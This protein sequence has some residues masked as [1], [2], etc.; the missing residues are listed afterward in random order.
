MDINSGQFSGYGWNGEELGTGGN[1]AN[2]LGWI[3]F[4][5]AKGP[6]NPLPGGCGPALGKTYCS[7]GLPS[8]PPAASDLCNSES[9]LQG[10]APSG[11]APWNWQCVSNTCPGTVASCGPVNYTP[12][13]NGTCGTDDGVNFCGNS[14]LPS[15]LCDSGT[16][17]PITTGYSEYTWTCGSATCGGITVNC[18]APG[19]H[20][21]WKEV[22]P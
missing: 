1:M 12:A 21:G 18:S 5:K 15:N 4:A 11:S 16:A 6:C 22:N 7:S 17:S 19:N 8:G 3:N 14:A 2:G 13:D 9:V 20:C 10:S